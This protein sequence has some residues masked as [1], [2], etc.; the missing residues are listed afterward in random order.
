MRRPKGIGRMSDSWATE[1][2]RHTRFLYRSPDI[3]Q[4]TTRTWRRSDS[5][6]DYCCR[7]ELVNGA[8]GLAWTRRRCVS[9]A[10]SIFRWSISSRTRSQGEHLATDDGLFQVPF[11]GGLGMSAEPT[12]CPKCNGAMV[13]GFTVDFH[14]GG[15][16]LVT[17]WVEG[18]PEKSF[19]HSTNVPPE[20]SVPVG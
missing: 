8:R 11:F 3:T 7:G 15:K 18:P 5:A 19:W 14:A 10:R 16:R 6:S 1:P 20:N 13:Q 2:H 9:F 12:R 17:N 4:N